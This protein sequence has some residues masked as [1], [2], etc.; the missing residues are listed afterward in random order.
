MKR[1]K[2]N[3]LVFFGEVVVLFAFNVSVYHRYVDNSLGIIA[4]KGKTFMPNDNFG[5]S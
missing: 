4:L 5:F 3:K 2:L 1:L